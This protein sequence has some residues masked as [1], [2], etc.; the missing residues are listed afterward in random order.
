MKPRSRK[1]RLRWIAAAL[2]VAAGLLASWFL[3]R[4]PQVEIAP[5]NRS[6]NGESP[7]PGALFRGEGEAVTNSAEGPA[8]TVFRNAPP[9]DG[10]PATAPIETV[11]DVL[12]DAVNLAAPG[13]RE[14]AL[15]RLRRG[16]AQR[17]A[18]ARETATRLGFPLRVVHPDGRVRELAGFVEG[19]PLYRETHNSNAAISTGADRLARA[20]FFLTGTGVTVGVW[21]GGG[22]LA[23]HQEF[24]TDSR[25]TVRDGAAA[26]D[27]ATHVAGTIAA[28]GLYAPSLGMAPAARI[29]SYDWNDDALELVSRGAASPTEPGMIFLSNH[30]YGYLKGWVWKGGSGTPARNWEWWG[31]GSGPTASEPAF[32]RYDESAQAGDAIAH[33]A[34]YFL[35]FWS[36][37]NEG[38]DNPS[39]G[40]TVSLSPFGSSVVNYDPALHPG[41]DG[42]HRGGYE[43]IG[44]L[45]IAKNLVTVGSV[46]DAESAG[47]RSLAPAELNQFSSTGP[48]DDGRIKPDLVANG[49]SLLSPIAQGTDWYAWS[50]G[51]SMS[52]PNAAGTA[53]LLVQ[54]YG[55]RFPGQAMRSSTLRGLLIHTADDLGTV[56][57]DY[58]YGWGLVNAFAAAEQIR[59]DSDH[60]L[61][62][63]IE[64]SVIT[65]AETS[66]TRE[67]LWDG[68]SPIVATLCWT[69]PPGDPAGDDSR[70]P[71]LVNNLDLKIVGPDG[72]EHLPWKMPF[73]GTWT[74]ASLGEPAGRG[75]NDTDN[76]EQ[77]RI[78]APS[79]PGRYRCVVSFRGT[80]QDD[81]QEY[82]ILVTGGATPEPPS[83]GN[84]AATAVGAF[85]ASLGGNITG[86][87]GSEITERGVVY[88][89]LSANADPV[90]GDP[91]VTRV[92][93]SG[94]VGAFSVSV[95]GLS[96][97]TDYRYK[98]YA[99]NVRGTSYTGAE[100]VTTLSNNADLAGL[101]L[102]RGTLSPTFAPGTTDYAVEVPNAT[103][104][105]SV[106]A[107]T[108]EAGANLVVRINGGAGIS[109]SSG[110][111][112]PV[113]P[114]IVGTNLLEIEVNAE[115]GVTDK[116]YA[117]MVTRDKASQTITFPNPGSRNAAETVKLSASGGGSGNPVVFTV[118]GPAALGPGDVLA[119]T[120]AG[121]VT[122]RA[123]QAGDELHR[124]ALEVAQ[125]FTVTKATAT[126]TLG[127]LSQNYDGTPK[128][129]T[130]I[131]DPLGRAVVI[132]YDDSTT[133]PAE[134]GFYA[135][136]GA[137][138]DPIYQGSASRTLVIVKAAQSITFDPI[139]DKTTTDTVALSAS[140]GASGN[141]VTFA[142]TGG[143]ARI[144]DGTLSFIGAGSVTITASQAGSAN[145]EAAVNVSR[146]FTV[147]K[148]TATVTLG[149]LSQTYDGTPKAATAITDPLGRAVV[150]TYDD[151][152]TVPAEAGFYA[153]IGAISDPIYQGSAS[154]TLF[155]AKASQTIT[156]ATIADQLATATVNLPATGGG[157]GNPVTFAVTSGPGS[158]SGGNILTFSGAGSVT[159]TASQAG[160]TNHEPATPVLRSF[161]VTE[162]E[163]TVTLSELH[164]VADDSPRV[165]IATTTPPDLDVA[166]TYAG[167]TAAPTAIGS[168]AVV[169]TITDP[170][171]EGATDGTLVV[172]DPATMTL[173]NGGQLPAVSALGAL[174]VPTY[175]IARYEVTRGLWNTVRDWAIANGYD[176]AAISDGL[177]ND[178]PIH[179]LNWYD[180]IK[181]CNARTEW[182]NATFGRS[183]A[184]AYRIGTAVF[185]A[186]A[187]DP[188]AV[189][190]DPATSGY[191]LPMAS[192]WEYAARGGRSGTGK[193][194]AGSNDPDPVA[195]HAG[196]S[197][198]A[199]LD[200]SDGRGTWP[201]G[202]KATNELGLHDFSGNVAEWTQEANPANPSMRL[203][204]GGS[205]NGTA[206]ESAIGALNSAAPSMRLNTNGFRVARSVA[207]AIAGALD[208]DELTWNSGGDQPWF[209]GIGM[210][211]DTNDG[212]DAAESGA[213][214]QDEE[215][216]IETT[217]T[218]PGN[219]SFQW[220]SASV[221]GADV[222]RFSIGAS[223]AT[224]LTGTVDWQK[225]TFEIPA[226]DSV[227]RWR[228]ARTS[229][230]NAGTSRVW[231]DEVAYTLATE[232]V[233]TTAAATEVT[234]TTA[235][236]GGEVTDEG[237]R[238]V[239]ERGVVYATTTAP[240]L[241]D[242]FANAATGGTG[243]FI[244]SGTGLA[245]GTTYHARA[246][247]TNAIGTGYGPEIT[248]TTGASANF[249]NG[250]ATFSRSLLPGGRQVFNFTL[251]GPR[252]VSLSTL[253]DGTPRAELYDSEGNLIAS[254]DGDTNFDLEELLLAGGYALHILREEDGGPARTFD[255]TIDAG[256]VAASLPD[257]A[258][259]AS[260]GALQG[261]GLHAPTKQLVALV[262]KKAN[263]VV[264]YAGLSNGGNLPDVLAARASGGN[265][266]FAVS[267]FD[268]TGNVTA[269]LLAG[270]YTTP[271]MDEKATPVV[272]RAI[273]APNKKKLTRKK[274]G[275]KPGILRKTHLLT[276]R[277][278]STFDPAIGDDA[279]IS[280]QTK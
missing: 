47:A 93:A 53:A 244:A 81:R 42:Q 115:D 140:G 43:T 35:M 91:G 163:A 59:A 37:G 113:Q 176:L 223:E 260:P 46:L 230:A 160:D 6:I 143:P 80:L 138:S 206:G 86:D 178:H 28:A 267:Y 17:L 127:N 252:I 122:V 56:G 241:A 203:L 128:A 214:G 249:V 109:V 41:G 210:S 211:H 166:I 197:D 36:A 133:V 92:T 63:R 225:Q 148:A 255:L 84:P 34:P 193:T 116:T 164:Q 182:E 25:V 19:R 10:A 199:A 224:S 72:S 124:A 189:L 3:Q 27:H 62:S 4:G 39:P 256:T 88:S 20:P 183:L 132:T 97:G 83:V 117:V 177:A 169:A 11:A 153:V 156:F 234:E 247:A 190:V 167:A 154:R 231:L 99:I 64:E 105:V 142:V 235:T 23:T 38:I 220:K 259:G 65:S 236:L 52:S 135:V 191:R 77:V 157:S 198:G 55:S 233:L 119:F 262:S 134:A 106:T 31:S 251:A 187:P 118:E 274:K 74:T 261:V 101:S 151:S 185:K 278:T 277:L 24:A 126:V 44:H 268:A 73:V 172:D 168:Y 123:N 8:P 30:S 228:F 254:F 76:V 194:Y 276:L 104:S 107:T 131:T 85:G 265:T 257:V 271:E 2:V 110:A 188:A 60:P 165:V 202:R 173:I 237:G 120:G 130:A 263:A 14:A 96:P 174:D 192:E 180:A 240:T 146:S 279:T 250:R 213:L 33:A 221:D 139:P 78:E 50:S 145:Y 238:A 179:S 243:G 71:T 16:E 272:I 239:T 45:G 227:L 212:N 162:A 67:F 61:Q 246:Y 161:N 201:S 108:A 280:V 269:G 1:T 68:V 207:A 69:D 9:T 248:F 5:E 22:V 195:W 150:I 209:A 152:T 82:S 70:L 57:P 245:P 129:A 87:G 186:G 18:I 175:Q 222:L 66:R 270:T 273:I 159:I 264:G 21:D 216:W 226:G 219:L 40:D 147:T 137:I 196:N 232:P 111:A 215:S 95:T 253:G 12:A 171:Y 89:A 100:T 32:G 48:V 149:N 29:D 136:I 7:R 200:L 26:D 15:E 266:L 170:L 51:T 125:T 13:A 258:V 242:D 94:T 158:I 275:Q 102:D 98:A 217:V 103:D 49:D 155:V 205:W 90:I 58:R 184:P 79:T 75:L 141:P 144:T 208:N 121:T 229:P 54:E 218:G 204:L 181:W 114:L 112:S